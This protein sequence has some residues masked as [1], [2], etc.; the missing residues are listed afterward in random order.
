MSLENFRDTVLDL[1]EEELKE[2][3]EFFKDYV[4]R[5]PHSKLKRYKGYI[6]ELNDAEIM[7]VN[8]WDVVDHRKYETQFFTVETSKYFTNE[9][10][11]PNLVL[12]RPKVGDYKIITEF[13]G[14][15][16]VLDEPQSWL[17][18]DVAVLYVWI[19]P[20]NFFM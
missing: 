20:K 13:R 10:N 16:M 19:V 7:L 15:F 11:S 3:F 18:D 9:K 1:K 6:F 2:T 14:E 4:D 12:F 17:Y 8:G 5:Y